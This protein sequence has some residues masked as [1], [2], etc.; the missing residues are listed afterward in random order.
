MFATEDLRNRVVDWTVIAT[1][2]VL[3][4]PAAE[5]LQTAQSPSTSTAVLI[6]MKKPSIFDKLDRVKVANSPGVV[7]NDGQHSTAALKQELLEYLNDDLLDRDCCPLQWWAKHQLRYPSVAAPARELL[8]VP[9]TSVPGERL[10]SKAGDVITK[11]RNSLA[12][13]KADKVI[14]LMLNL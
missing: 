8:A 2:T 13:S 14:F 11:K 1:M 3:E 12:P 6:P 9:A 4:T 5:A 7:R 10:F